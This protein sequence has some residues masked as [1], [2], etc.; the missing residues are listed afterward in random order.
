MARNYHSVNNLKVSEN[1]LSFINNEL[2]TNIDISSEKFWLGFD[3]II[4]ELLYQI[5]SKIFLDQ[6]LYLLIIHH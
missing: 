4:H 1:L 3:K 2:L 6:Y 5:L